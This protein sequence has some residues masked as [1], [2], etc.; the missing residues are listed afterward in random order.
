[1]LI[2]TAHKTRMCG[3]AW[4]EPADANALQNSRGYGTK[5]I[6]FL[7]DVE[8][9]SAVLSSHPLRNANT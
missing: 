1:V 4:R 8:G 7:L 5:F 9:P 2:R 3:K 6:K